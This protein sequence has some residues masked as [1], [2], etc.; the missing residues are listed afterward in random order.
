MGIRLLLVSCL[1][2]QGCVTMVATNIGAGATV[3]AAAETADQAKTAADVVAYGTTGKTLT[4]HALDAVTGRDCKLF[5]VFNKNH[6]VCKERMPDLST[7]EKIKEFQ[8]SK[9]LEPTGTIGPKTRI[10][11]WR[12]KYEL[13]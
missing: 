9:G 8:R 10:A 4:D 2:L 6:K 11:I 1:L 5:N 13:D 7:R 12:I 3:I